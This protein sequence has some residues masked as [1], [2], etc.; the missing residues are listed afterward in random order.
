[1][2]YDDHSQMAFLEKTLQRM[3]KKEEHVVT[4]KAV[5]IKKHT[6][7]EDLQKEN[8]GNAMNTTS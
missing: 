3:R 5:Q 7:N 1:M 4:R 8:K 6:R 2:R